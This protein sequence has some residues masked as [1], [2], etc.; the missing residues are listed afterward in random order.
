MARRSAVV[1]ALLWLHQQA[2]RCQGHLSQFLLVRMLRSE[3]ALLCSVKLFPSHAHR[4]VIVSTLMQHPRQTGG[5]LGHR[6]GTLILLGN[7]ALGDVTESPMG[8]LWSISQRVFQNPSG[9][10]YGSLFASGRVAGSA[11][12][13]GSCA[14]VAFS[15]AD[16]CQATQAPCLRRGGSSGQTV[17]RYHHVFCLSS[18]LGFLTK[19]FH[20]YSRLLFS[21]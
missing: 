1:G 2:P 15:T 16:W 20:F 10:T 19:R 14:A 9:H 21:S 18:Q 17:Q 12:G 6:C 5:P 4:D 7:A 8:L 13:L 3:E 11:C